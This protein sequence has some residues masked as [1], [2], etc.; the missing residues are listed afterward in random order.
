MLSIFF[1]TT[2]SLSMDRTTF[3]R[4]IWLTM[5]LFL[6][7]NLTF[8]EAFLNLKGRQASSSQKKGVL[9]CVAS[10]LN[11]LHPG[12]SPAETKQA[13]WE[14]CPGKLGYFRLQRRS[15]LF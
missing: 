15:N 11:P 3:Q 12:L 4:S 9:V 14:L 5:R 6:Q 2:I 10:F 1:L 13:S 7:G 8:T